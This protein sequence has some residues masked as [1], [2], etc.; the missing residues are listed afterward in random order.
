MPTKEQI[1]AELKKRGEAIEEPAEDLTPGQFVRGELRTAAQIGRGTIEELR[2]QLLRLIPKMPELPATREFPPSRAITPERPVFPEARPT[3]PTKIGRTLGDILGFL[4]AGAAGRAATAALPA[5]EEAGPAAARLIRALRGAPGRIAGTALYGQAVSPDRLRGAERGAAFGAGAE[6]L[7]YIGKGIGAVSKYI[8]PMTLVKN[9]MNKLSG[10]EKLEENSQNFAKLLKNTYNN[11]I[12]DISNDLYNPI[13]DPIRN[14]SI[15][16]GRVKSPE[17][18]KTMFDPTLRHEEDVGLFDT[19]TRG[20]KKLHSAFKKNPTLQNAHD[21]QS[22]LGTEA[23]TI[24]RDPF[25][26]ISER[27]KA[28]GYED[29]RKNLQM[30][31]HHFLDFKDSTGNLTNRYINAGETFRKE[32]VPYISEKNIAEIAKG[33]ETNPSNIKTIFKSP[34]TDTNKIV[35]DMGSEAN[36]RIL[37]DELG[38]GDI[39]DANKFINR[40]NTLDDK[41]LQSYL[42]PA[43]KEDIEQIKTRILTKEGVERVAGAG[44][45]VGLALVPHAGITPEILAGVGGATLAPTIMRALR[46]GIPTQQISKGIGRAYP[47]LSKSAIATLLGQRPEEEEPPKPI[48]RAEAIAELKRRGI[49]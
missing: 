12:E 36:R 39:K 28:T 42:T 45:G 43:M 49:Q 41:R 7:P 24:R 15:H 11:K 26:K 34:D 17:L 18:Y 8:K 30:D 37:Y 33:H 2:D 32:A 4:G 46:R 47:W 27:D 6:A 38:R 3:V 13:L 1:D 14:N 20:L 25:S 5:A 44:A 31:I 10:G 40:I 19:Y 21:L 35:N 29:A 16:W 23:R 48:T 22:E 9:F